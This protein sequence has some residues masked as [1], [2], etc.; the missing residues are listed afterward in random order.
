MRRWGLVIGLMVCVLLG[1]EGQT[2]VDAQQVIETARQ[3]L[4][5]PYSYGATGPARFDC[6]GLVQLS[7]S[8]NGIQLPRTSSAMSNE[9]VKVSGGWDNLQAGDLVFF[10]SSHVN[11]VG[12]YVG[13]VSPNRHE[14]IHTSCS[15][16]VTISALEESYWKQHYLFAR[17]LD[18]VA[19]NSIAG[20]QDL[21]KQETR[22]TE[23]FYCGEL[24]LPRKEYSDIKSAVDGGVSY[25]SRHW[26]TRVNRRNREK[27][28]WAQ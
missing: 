13:T 21:T 7:F 28:V 20:S 22:E 2:R 24:L 8:K 26:K 18:L 17:R 4:G 9:G 12:I 16:G 5:C 3:Y 6:S 10:G 14:F 19:T 27:V 11:H 23:G 15:L 1:A 25:K